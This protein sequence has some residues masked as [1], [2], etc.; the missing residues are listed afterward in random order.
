MATPV[1]KQNVSNDCTCAVASLDDRCT[2][3]EILHR[4]HGMARVGG[5]KTWLPGRRSLSASNCVQV[6]QPIERE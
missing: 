2:P 6:A 4:T 5:L 3:A 1:P